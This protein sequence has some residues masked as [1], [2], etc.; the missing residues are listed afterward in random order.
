MKEKEWGMRASPVIATEDNI[1]KVYPPKSCDIITLLY[2][3]MYNSGQC[4]QSMSIITPPRVI[5]SSSE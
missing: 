1:I 2:V 5:I 3:A 4:D